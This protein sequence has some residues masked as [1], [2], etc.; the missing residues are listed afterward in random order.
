MK[1]L[2]LGQ[3]D[4]PLLLFG[5]P[6][7]NLQASVALRE[8]ALEN[9]YRADQ[10]ICTGDLV[11][12]CAQPVET[13]ALWRDFGCAILAGNCEQQLADNALDC[14]CGFES[15]TACDLLSAGWYAHANALVDEQSRAW[16]GTLPELMHFTHCGKRYAVVH[17]G[18][19]AINR[20]IWPVSPDAVFEE[21]FAAIERQ[22]G[23]VDAVIAGHAGMAFERQIGERL[24]INAG[25]IGLPANNGQ[26]TTE[27]ALMDAG[28]V[29]L[30]QLTYDHQSAIAAMS[31]AKLTQGYHATLSSGLWPSEDVLPP[32]MRKQA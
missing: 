3:L 24:W 8:Y 9:G 12:Y 30:M 6:Y 14:G 26:T 10:V 32:E 19:T 2:D 28:R 18:A 23:P 22:I 27:F 31:R 29:R 21:E 16:M 11:A 1:I 4:T 15:G 17:G 25:A 7:S 20:F 13:V 5:G